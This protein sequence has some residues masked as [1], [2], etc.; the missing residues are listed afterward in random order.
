MN[1]NFWGHYG[2]CSKR[3]FVYDRVTCADIYIS[4]VGDLAHFE[5]DRNIVGTVVFN[6]SDITLS[7]IDADS[8]ETAART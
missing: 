3:P 1:K 7:V 5:I 8:A 4:V 2:H 6:R